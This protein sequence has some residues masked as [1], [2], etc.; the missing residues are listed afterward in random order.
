MRTKLLLG[1]AV[2]AAGLATSMAQNVYSLNVV[3]Y[4][5]VTVKGNG[6]TL[7]ANQLT[8]DT[9]G[10]NEVIPTAGY[11]DEVLT[12]VNNDYNIDVFDG[13]EWLD[14][15]SGNPSTTV[16][17]PGKGFFY[18]SANPTATLTFVGQVPQGRL[19]SRYRRAS[20]W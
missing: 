7:I 17:P 6:L 3:G 20:P 15:N 18:Q 4:Y 5:N 2:L 12:F 19:P 14:N 8:V 9:N 11:A 1:A 16:L 13:T 10:L